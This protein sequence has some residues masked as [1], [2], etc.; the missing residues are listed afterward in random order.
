LRRA[1]FSIPAEAIFDFGFRQRTPKA[2]KSSL[3]RR[4]ALGEA[5]VFFL[6]FTGPGL[7][8]RQSIKAIATRMPDV[9]S[10]CRQGGE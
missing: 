4:R 9:K 2:G 1:Q 5:P 8:A 6:F 10:S 7:A 3:T